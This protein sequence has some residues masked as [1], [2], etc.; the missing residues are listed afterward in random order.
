M[1]SKIDFSVDKENAENKDNYKN[2]NK[3]IGLHLH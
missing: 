1:S 3:A 2:L